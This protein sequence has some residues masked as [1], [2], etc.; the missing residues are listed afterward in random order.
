MYKMGLRSLAMFDQ[1]ANC[2]VS[3]STNIA[4]SYCGTNEGHLLRILLLVNMNC[5][6]DMDCH[7]QWSY[8]QQN[9]LKKAPSE[10]H[11]G[12]G[13]QDG[14]KEGVSCDAFLMYAS[15]LL[16]FGFTRIKLN[17]RSTEISGHMNVQVHENELLHHKVYQY[18]ILNQTTPL[19]E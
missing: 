5:L 9:I 4:L 3:H 6:G 19:N 14:S 13:R 16:L 12:R 7:V 11:E 18:Y 17:Y 15:L 1:C 8:H 10:T 2:S